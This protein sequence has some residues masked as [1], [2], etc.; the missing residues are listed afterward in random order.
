MSKKRRERKLAL[1]AVEMLRKQH[2]AAFDTAKPLAIGI[3]H[4]IVAVTDCP[5]HQVR[6]GLRYWTGR[7]PYLRAIRDG[8]CRYALDG[9]PSGEVTEEDQAFASARIALWE[10]PERVVRRLELA[11]K[12]TRRKTLFWAARS[13]RDRGISEIEATLMPA[14]R[15]AGLKTRE[16]RETIARALSQ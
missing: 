8:G 11:V 4:Q 2:P 12:G 15:V 1:L 14:A 9:S 7:G 6:Y 5:R 3:F 13:L 16:V 10:D